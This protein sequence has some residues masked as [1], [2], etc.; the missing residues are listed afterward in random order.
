MVLPGHTQPIIPAAVIIRMVI[1]AIRKGR[2]WRFAM[3]M[4]NGTMVSG[5]VDPKLPNHLSADCGR[6]FGP[7]IMWGGAIFRLRSA[8]KA[9]LRRDGTQ[10]WCS[11][12]SWRRKQDCNCSNEGW[13]CC[14]QTVSGETPEQPRDAGANHI[15]RR[16]V[17]WMAPQILS[18][19]F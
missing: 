2:T 13:Q 18:D 19:H 14:R 7:A 10:F 3:V 4:W 12:E 16:S 8:P 15:T 1:S 11:A 6:N 17:F 9:P 5:S